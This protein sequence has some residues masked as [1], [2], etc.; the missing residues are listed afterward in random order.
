M[1]V[2]IG[3][4]DE[5]LSATNPLA[6]MLLLAVVIVCEHVLFEVV[7]TSKPFIRA[8]RTTVLSS[9]GFGLPPVAPTLSVYISGR[10]IRM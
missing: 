6:D 8:A 1:S 5:L 7:L 9:A 4:P 2:Q 10:K 3:F